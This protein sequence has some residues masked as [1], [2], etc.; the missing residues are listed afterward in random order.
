MNK[1]SEPPPNRGRIIIA[2]GDLEAIKFWLRVFNLEPYVNVAAAEI[3]AQTAPE[4]N[5]GSVPIISEHRSGQLYW[6]YVIV[7]FIDSLGLSGGM[8]LIFYADGE[9]R[10]QAEEKRDEFA[11]DIMQMI[12]TQAEAGKMTGTADQGIKLFSQGDSYIPHP[13]G[14]IVSSLARGVCPL[15]EKQEKKQCFFM[16]L[17][18][19]I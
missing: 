3:R 2:D 6:Y 15:A 16:Q 18:H 19:F 10:A 11:D 4:V 17:C 7:L 9:H 13:Q 1:R 8:G 12:Q 5:Q 14:L